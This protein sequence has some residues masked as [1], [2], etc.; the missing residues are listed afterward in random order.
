LNQKKEENDDLEKI[1]PTLLGI[2]QK[3]ILIQKPPN[4]QIVHY[5]L[6]NG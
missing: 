6:E 2:E 1:R 5:I 4:D 3:K